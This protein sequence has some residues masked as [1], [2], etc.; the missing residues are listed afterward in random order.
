MQGSD[1]LLR[2]DRL[3][4]ALLLAAV[5][6]GVVLGASGCSLLGKK[7]V[8]VVAPP[9]SAVP[10]SSA[11]TSS[12]AAAPATTSPPPVVPPAVVRKR[13]TPPKSTAP[14]PLAT[15]L[16]AVR[17]WYVAWFM[18]DMN[19]AKRVSTTRFAKTINEGTFEGGDVTAYKI[20]GTEGA[21]G[22]E[23]FY[24]SETR[25]GQTQKQA[26]T[27]LVGM[28]GA[29]GAFLVKGYEQTAAGT[30]PAS[31]PPADST[32]TVSVTAARTAVMSALY[33]LRNDRVTRAKTFATSRFVDANPRWF[34]PAS[35]ALLKYSVVS[36]ARRHNVW[37]VRTSQTWRS[38][39][40]YPAFV[41]ERV[42]G[43]ARIDRVSDWY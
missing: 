20:L 16:G 22:T 40:Y 7:G 14:R 43:K 6:V 21:A 30:V 12:T 38:G 35:G 26:M 11:L 4:G 15:Q 32:S 31:P 23:A 36:A 24:V 3:G 41:V 37:I 27:V 18:G 42:S 34:S 19:A 29:G 28:T 8:P 2:V 17:A 5:L 1:R 13:P 9:S 25:Q 10:T 33:D 39:V